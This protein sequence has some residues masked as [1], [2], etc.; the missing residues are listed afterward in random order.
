M[1][2]Q[3]NSQQARQY[4]RGVKKKPRRKVLVTDLRSTVLE[5]YP[6]LKLKPN[7]EYKLWE[8][9]YKEYFIAMAAQIPEVAWG[10][11]TV[12]QV[13][14][15][16]DKI[17]GNP[18]KRIKGLFSENPYNIIVL[19][20]IDSETGTMYPYNMRSMRQKPYVGMLGEIEMRMFKMGY[21]ADWSSSLIVGD[22]IDKKMAD[23]ALVDYLHYSDFLDNEKVNL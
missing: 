8:Y 14:D 22:S 5:E 18:D 6:K 19:S 13:R 23:N 4:M 10:D 2:Q 7:V 20:F 1:N 11:Q 16:F 17:V 3:L 9:K 21:I 15:M 12:S